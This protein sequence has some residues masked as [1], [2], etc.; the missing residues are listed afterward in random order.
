MGKWHFGW[1][2]GMNKVVK[3][4][5]N[6]IQ[7]REPICHSRLL[8]HKPQT[9]SNKTWR[10]LQTKLRSLEFMLYVMVS[11]WKGFASG[12]N[13]VKSWAWERPAGNVEGGLNRYK[14]GGKETI[15]TLKDWIRVMVEEGRMTRR[16]VGE[17]F[18]EG[19]WQ[20][21]VE[22]GCVKRGVYACEVTSVVFDSLWLHEL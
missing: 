15:N 17:I 7:E 8:Q 20:N 18:T 3:L 21:W 4:K 1:G 19:N 6:I 14:T 13:M 5:N 22:T 2:K 11:H 10:A 9:G 16:P 12:G